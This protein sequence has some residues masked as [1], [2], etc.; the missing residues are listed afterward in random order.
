MSKITLPFGDSTVEC[1]YCAVSAS[2]RALFVHWRK[3][4]TTLK[5]EGRP[6]NILRDAG[7][8]LGL[9]YFWGQELNVPGSRSGAQGKAKESWLTW[10]AFLSIA[11]S[12]APT[13]PV[14]IALAKR[15]LPSHGELNVLCGIP[16]RRSR[17]ELGKCTLE[18]SKF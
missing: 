1:F 10:S 7:L 12:M 14:T 18:F 2:E 3:A 8:K 4:K 6:M 17:T 9:H 16:S 5:I 15:A 13:S 11:F